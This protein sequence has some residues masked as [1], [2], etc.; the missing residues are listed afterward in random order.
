MPNLIDRLIT[1]VDTI[2]QRAADRFGLPSYNLYRVIRTYTGDEVGEGSY[3]DSNAL[4]TPTPMVEIKA[5]DMLQGGGRVEVGTMVAKEISLNYTEAYLKG[6]GLAANQ[7]CFYKLTERNSQATATTYWIITSVRP[8]R[9]ELNW[10]I[11][12]KRY[13]A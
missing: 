3:T 13:E 9:E 1:K 7:A 4:I 6:T 5:S 12:F 11:D 2:R 8:H 10:V